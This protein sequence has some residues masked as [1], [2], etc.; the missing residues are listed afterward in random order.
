MKVKI[1]KTGDGEA[2]F[3]IPEIL[4]KELQWNE[5]DQI[6]WMDNKDGSWTLRKVGFEGDIQS[7]SIEYILSQHPNLKDQVE[8]V[9]DDSDLRTEWL[10][11]AIPALSGLTPLEVVLKGDLKRVLDALNRIKYGDIS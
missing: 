1:E 9:F 7:K 5:G 2:F 10:T 8:D 4:Q 11:S 6:E 3:N